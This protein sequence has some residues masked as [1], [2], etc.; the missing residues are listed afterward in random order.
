VTNIYSLTNHGSPLYFQNP[1]QFYQNKP[2]ATL[3]SDPFV[4]QSSK[5]NK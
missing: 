4:V 2:V 3:L 1:S 5:R